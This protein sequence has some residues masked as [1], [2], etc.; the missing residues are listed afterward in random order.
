MTW[1][2]AVQTLDEG[3]ATFV[4]VVAQRPTPES[5]A[6]ARRDAW[7]VRPTTIIRDTTKRKGETR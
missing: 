1:A 6:R 2:V 4:A 3:L 7:R 5:V